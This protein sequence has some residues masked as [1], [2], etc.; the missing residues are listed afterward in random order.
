VKHRFDSP[1]KYSE[2]DIEDILGFLVGNVYVVV[3]GQGLQQS[4]S[5]P[6]G[7]NC[8]PLLANLFL[9]SCEAEFVQKMLRNKKKLALSLNHTYRHIDDVLSFNNDQLQIWKV[10]VKY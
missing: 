2:A 4:V 1:Y 6:M 3:G 9:Y 8:A 7:T 5:I 10:V